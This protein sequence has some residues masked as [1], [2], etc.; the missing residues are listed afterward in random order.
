M[1]H[2]YGKG[3]GLEVLTRIHVCTT[4]TLHT[5]KYADYACGVLSSV[6]CGKTK[7]WKIMWINVPH[8]H[9]V[10]ACVC[11][12]VCVSECALLIF[13]VTYNVNAT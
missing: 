8:A 12:C 6:T 2:K 3:Q 1:L 10:C 5:C 9:V 7:A 11:V 4:D 13:S